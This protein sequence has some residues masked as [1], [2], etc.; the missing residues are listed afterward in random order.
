MYISDSVTKHISTLK[1]LNLRFYCSIKRFKFPN[2]SCSESVSM[3]I[4]PQVHSV[5]GL[6]KVNLDMA[7]FWF[8][9]ENEISVCVRN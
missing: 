4:V 3:S 8:D 7:I 6:F 1:S 5:G 9:L 2:M